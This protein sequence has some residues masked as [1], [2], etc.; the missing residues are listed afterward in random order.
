[1]D[2]D[3]EQNL[4]LDNQKETTASLAEHVLY[5][6]VEKVLYCSPDESYSVIRVRDH[7]GI[8]HIVVGLLPG[9]S[10]GEVVEVHGKWEYHKEHGRQLR[11]V[12]CTFSLPVTEQG[13]VRYLSSGVIKGVGKKYA[14]QIVGTFGLETLHVLDNASQRLKEVPGLGQ[15]RISQIKKAWKESSSKRNLQIFMAGL[16]I[17]PAFFARIY[18]QYGD[19]CSQI[20]QQDPYRLCFDVKGIGF[21]LADKIA[22]KQ[23]IEKT[24]P[25]RLLAG[26]K[27]CLEQARGSGH[28]CMPC[29]AF[30][31]QTAA[32]LDVSFEEIQ[33]M[34]HLAEQQGILMKG[35]A[36]DD[37]VYLYEPRMLQMENELPR[38]LVGLIRAGKHAGLKLPQQV[39]SKTVNFS[40]EQI[41]AVKQACSSAVSILTGGPGVG[42]TTVISEIVRRAKIANLRFVL[43]APTGRAAKRMQETTGEYAQTIHRLLKWD[44]AKGRFVY[45]KNNRLSQQLF[46][47]DE[48]SMLD[49]PLAS[50]LF[51]AIPPGACV[52]LV[53]DPDQ[54]PSVGPGNVLND[55]IDSEICPVSRLTK[56]F[57]QGEGSGII[58]AAH[59]V[60]G[61]SL[62]EL[63][64]TTG[65]LSDFYWIQK[66]DAEETAYLIE[67]LVMERIP[68]RFQM[69]PHKDIQVLCPMNRGG[70]GTVAI[71]ERLQKLLN[72]E[73]KM[74]FR[75]G[76]RLFKRGDRIM[77]TCNNYDKGIFNGDLG[78]I[79]SMD[80]AAESF[81]VNFDNTLVE[82]SFDEADQLVLAYA[83]TVHKSQGSEFPV[84]VMPLLGQHYK[85]LQRN[86]LYTGM[87]RAKRLM[88]LVGSKKAVSMAVRNSVREPRYSLLYEK[89]K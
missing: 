66:D 45:D 88:V 48:V 34:I 77:Q 33:Q 19:Q 65:E 82:Y 7:Q 3:F 38:L 76:D 81:M 40:D 15:K 27:H 62:P 64:E 72:P 54:L 6:E 36:P 59:A 73:N 41:A 89:L 16:G 60:N 80:L 53:G 5:G 20:I 51:R 31:D 71:N 37:S 84:V 24:N 63:P 56:I 58:R 43:A 57:R 30:A 69:D 11:A 46:I 78:R 28:V 9:A 75:R 67:R 42:K 18:A 8:D 68:K 44:P 35:K 10:Q 22:A 83:I 61:G 17:T 55:L 26:I 74:M 85:M 12:S 13:I 23:G 50:A 2:Q 29:D 79:E 39:G 25:K 4:F 14:E 21:L 70:A 32:L 47:I 87:T 52:V 86:L 49:L 1:M